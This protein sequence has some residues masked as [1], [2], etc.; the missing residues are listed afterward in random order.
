MPRRQRLLS[1]FLNGRRVTEDCEITKQKLVC[2]GSCPIGGQGH[3]CST[4]D[5]SNF[6]RHMQN[7]HGDKGYGNQAL[8]FP[9][10]TGGCTVCKAGFKTAQ[11]LLRHY[12]GKF[13]FQRLLKVEIKCD[14][15]VAIKDN[16]WWPEMASSKPVF[17]V[18][19]PHPEG[20]CFQ[21]MFSKVSTMEFL[22]LCETP[23]SER[24]LHKMVFFKVHMKWH[25]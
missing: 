12:G 2:D 4:Q 17:N 9:V 16:R 1:R 24:G 22:M 3:P 10:V 23:G 18:L 21:Q 7:W 8:K 5:Q 13:C 11:A 14:S 20:N 15:V 6:K 19:V 25:Y